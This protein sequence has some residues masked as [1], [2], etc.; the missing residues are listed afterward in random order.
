MEREDNILAVKA[1]KWIEALGKKVV[2]FEIET[3]CV[4]G[5]RVTKAEKG[6]LRFSITVTNDMSDKEGNWHMGAIATIIDNLGAAAIGSSLGE[7][8]AS[9]CFDISYFSAAKVGEEV[10]IEA[11]LLENRDKFSLVTVEVKR[12]DDGKLIALGK[13]WM[14]SVTRTGAHPSKL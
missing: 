9:V 6:L 11:K 1:K 12:K 4:E 13:Q 10:E 3:R 2:G 8:K 14:S 7:V 5:I